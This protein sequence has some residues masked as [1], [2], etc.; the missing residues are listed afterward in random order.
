MHLDQDAITN[1]STSRATI[2]SV[3][4]YFVLNSVI[5]ATNFGLYNFIDQSIAAVRF[6]VGLY[7]LACTALYYLVLHLVH[8][9]RIFDVTGTVFEVAD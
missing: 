7:L 6:D 4:N 5:F 1:A 8:Q 2:A 3:A 9:V